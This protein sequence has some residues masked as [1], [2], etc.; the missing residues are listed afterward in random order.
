MTPMMM[1]GPASG[2]DSSRQSCLT[3]QWKV[4]ESGLQGGK[5]LPRG[6]DEQLS[7]VK[8]GKENKGPQV[9]ILATKWRRQ[10]VNE[11]GLRFPR[12]ERRSQWHREGGEK[13]EQESGTRH[14]VL[15]RRSFLGRAPRAEGSFG[16]R[17][18]ELG[19]ER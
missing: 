16:W 13:A 19:R 4:V 15:G 14:L 18:V 1:L 5:L 12:G 17:N 2:I 10:G 3:C 7:G 8:A 6:G 9:N 11:L